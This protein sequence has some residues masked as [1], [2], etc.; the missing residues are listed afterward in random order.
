[1]LD[2][3][4]V[5]K[6]SFMTEELEVFKDAVDRFVVQECVPHVAQ[7]RRDREVPREIWLK[8][9]RAGLLLASAPAEYGGGGGSM[10]HE[11][12]I[13]DRLGCHDALSFFVSVQNIGCAPYIVRFASEAQKR[14]WLPKMASG[15]WIGGMSMTEPTAGSD[16]K[17]I[18]MSAIRDGDH[19]ILN[20]QKLFTTLGWFA[21]I[22][23]VA[24]K[25][26]SAGAHGISL[27]MVET[28]TPG[29]SRGHRLDTLGNVAH[30]V[31]ELF[32]DNVR[33]PAEN[34]LGGL[35]GH[36]F[37][38]MMANLVEERLI[39]IIEG[40]AM[41]E[42]ALADT[43]SYV[44]DRRAFGQAII[45]FQNTQFVLADCKTEATIAK[46]FVNHLIE[47]QLAGQLDAV[48]SAMGKLWVS[49]MQGRVIDRCLQLFG[50]YG[51]INEYP[52]AH[53]YK[54]ARITRIGGG[55]SE[56]MRVI[57]GRSL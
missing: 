25:T 54:D 26:G 24:C 45:D 51:Y 43:V 1:M 4:S 2:V 27:F 31:A 16:L 37:A 42:R 5:P 28:A 41:V 8:A 38:Q 19:Y 56:I 13:M 12:V 15:E 23:M 34:L 29:V 10:A 44:K 11:A 55:T 52:I 46:V 39:C 18:K 57:I 3:I 49:E 40:M 53:M 22:L 35:E 33:V 17:A 7:W 47:R 32:F 21:D 48:T 30:G 36:G 14:L 20:G 50:G 9:G 6:P